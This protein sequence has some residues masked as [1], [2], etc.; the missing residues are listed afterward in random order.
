MPRAN[1]IK[2]VQEATKS[3]MKMLIKQQKSIIKL[4]C[5]AKMPKKH[6][7]ATEATNKTKFKILTK[8]DVVLC[9]PKM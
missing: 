5:I 1:A 2:L 9:D 3:L 8:E 6:G 7:N 4:P